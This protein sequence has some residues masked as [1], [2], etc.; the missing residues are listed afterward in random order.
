MN[1]GAM[2]SKNDTLL[3][4]HAD[5]LLPKSA[6]ALISNALTRSDKH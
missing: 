2:K 6:P 1:F 3:F 4:L 5:T